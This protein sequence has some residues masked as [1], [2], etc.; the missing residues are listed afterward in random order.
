[1]HDIETLMTY[2]DEN[3]DN[4]RDLLD[5]FLSKDIKALNDI[6]APAKM[7]K[8]SMRMDM[9]FNGSV[10]D[11]A[12][13]APTSRQAKQATEQKTT[14]STLSNENRKLTKRV[15]TLT[16]D[17]NRA[18]QQHAKDITKLTNKLTKEKDKVVADLNKTIQ[19]L[20]D[21]K[22]A[23][24]ASLRDQV[25]NQQANCQA[26]QAA[27]EQL[28]VALA[29][30][31]AQQAAEESYRLQYFKKIALIS[32]FQTVPLQ[33]K[34]QFNVVNIASQA[35]VSSIIERI[36]ASKVTEVWLVTEDVPKYIQVA[37]QQQLKDVI[38]INES[39]IALL[40]TQVED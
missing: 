40:N 9:H 19:A 37:I 25:A 4:A 20:N 33:L 5:L 17:L 1:M 18:K 35:S 28:A 2:I 10:N 11:E 23:Q 34:M 32:K 36:K 30:L 24:L 29:Q 14:T 15:K 22:D 16:A 8:F 27:K 12:K 21:K 3:I 39:R 6:F 7:D 38:I 13:Q 26:T 31:Q